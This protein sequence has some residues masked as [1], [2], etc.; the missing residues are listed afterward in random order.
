MSVPN[1]SATIK[2]AIERPFDLLALHRLNPSRYPYL[3]ESVAEG[4]SLGRYDLLFAFPQES[5]RLNADFSLSGRSAAATDCFLDA[6]DCWWSQESSPPMA[7]GDQPFIGGWFMLLAYELAQQI[8]PSLDL[9]TQSTHPVAI[10]SRVPI[11]VVR[12]RH[13]RRT[14]I[15]AEAGFDAQVRQIRLDLDSL[16][17]LEKSRPRS[18]WSG[19]VM[20]RA[21]VEEDPAEFME[22]VRRAQ[23]HIAAGDIF[24]ANLSR[25]WCGR[26]SPGIEPADLYARLRTSNPAPFAGL[27]VFDEVAVISSSPER[28]LRIRGDIVETRPIAG[29]RPRGSPQ[30]RDDPLHAELLEDPK[31][32]AEHIMVIDLERNDLGRICRAGSVEVDEFMVIESYSHVHHIVSNIRGRLIDDATPGKIIAAIFPGGSITGCPKVRCM[33]IISALEGRARGLYT[34]AMGYINRDGSGDLSI[35]IRCMTMVGRELS[36]ATGC[37]I[38]SD[39]NPG[40]ELAETRA[41]AK[42]LILALTDSET[43]RTDRSDVQH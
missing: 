31:E 16:P 39:S 18:D 30:D 5:L 42:G 13:E 6:F 4:N 21:I 2:T 9:Q 14:W 36:L 40:Q 20:E 32:R 22:N 8:E 43:S 23:N 25:R 12:D 17:A 3:L 19:S 34:G 29:T 24:Q 10:A 37:G 35:L 11:A 27:A 1:P 33:E 7:Q 15:T 41:K 28:L 26:L 38:V